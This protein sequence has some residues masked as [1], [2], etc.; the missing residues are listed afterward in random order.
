[1]NIDLSEAY[2]A[3]MEKNALKYPAEQYRG[4]WKL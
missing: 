4:K 2:L 3:K 1:M